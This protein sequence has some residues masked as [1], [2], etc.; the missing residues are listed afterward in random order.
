MGKLVFTSRWWTRGS[1]KI[2]QRRFFCVEA[3]IVWG[4]LLQWAWVT[5][6]VLL[7][8]APRKIYLNHNNKP[9]D[10]QGRFSPALK[11]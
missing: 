8:I 10:R 4:D 3:L 11:G 1:D 6:E 5:S 7:P 2:K 9:P